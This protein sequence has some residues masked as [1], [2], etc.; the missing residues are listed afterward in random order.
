MS[1]GDLPWEWQKMKRE[2]TAPISVLMSVYERESPDHLRQ[3]LESIYRQTLPADEVVLVEDG[4]LPEA[5]VDVLSVYP[6][7]TVKLRENQGL[8]IALGEG[9]KHC[10]NAWIARMDSDDIMVPER[11]R[12]QW[13]YICRHPEVSVCGG[14][15]R[16]FV[17]DP[18]KSRLKRMP[19]SH[20][21]LYRYG[22]YRNPMNHM[23][24]VFRKQDVIRC[25]GYRDVQG[26]EDYDLWIRMLAGG[27]KLLNMDAVLVYARMGCHFSARRGGWGYFRRYLRLRREQHALGYTNAAEYMISV[28]LTFVMTLSPGFI[29]TYLYSGL[30]EGE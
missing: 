20:K 24:V 28:V 25:G 1:A 16:E 5:L 19:L 10:R 12:L 23:T 17:S 6:V 4:P 8:G 26:M 13:E 15:I 2:K 14:N 29:R 21:S 27:Y 18:K 11:M 3:A 30:R 9:M 7:K 22:K